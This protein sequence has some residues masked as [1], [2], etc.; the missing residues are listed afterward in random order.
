M[1][2]SIPAIA[3]LADAFNFIQ[4]SW[5]E[6]DV[7]RWK[8]ILG[9]SLSTLG[10]HFRIWATQALSSQTM[11]SLTAQTRSFVTAGP[12]SIIRNPLY[13]GTLLTVSGLM[14]WY[15]WLLFFA[16]MVL[17]AWRFHRISKYEGQQLIAR[18]GA[19]YLAYESAVPRWL[20]R[21]IPFSFCRLEPVSLSAIAS[22]SPFVALML[23]LWV[24]AL[25]GLTG[26]VFSF[27]GAG[28]LTAGGF[29]LC[30]RLT[31]KRRQEPASALA[32]HHL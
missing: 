29:I 13:L 16:V 23:A 7:A 28:L 9:A 27:L 12:F 4:G 26:F 15:G 24:A 32:P 22:N 31:S 11:L 8:M 5:F 6:P 18:W 30:R 3:I 19:A 14:I 21:R 1:F 2:A 20:P 17:H 25:T 10:I